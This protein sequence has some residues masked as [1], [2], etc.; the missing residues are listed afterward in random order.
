MELH[1]SNFPLLCFN[2]QLIYAAGRKLGWY[3]PLE[4]RVEHVS[5][6]LVLGEDKLAPIFLRTQNLQHIPLFEG[7][8]MTLNSTFFEQQSSVGKTVDVF[9]QIVFEMFVESYL[10]LQ[11]PLLPLW[12]SAS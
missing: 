1:I 12:W 3:S 7:D 4:K 9:F 6:G 8:G 10:I 11:V 2:F 5:F